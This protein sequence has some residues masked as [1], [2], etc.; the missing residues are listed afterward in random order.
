MCVNL[1]SC[2]GFV[3][4]VIISDNAKRSGRVR[5][6]KKG[7]FMTGQANLIAVMA[8]ILAGAL[9][10]VQAGQDNEDTAQG[11]DG[12]E[13]AAQTAPIDEE[14]EEDPVILGYLE[15]VQIGNLSLR[16]KGKL[17]T[18]ADTSSVHA[19]D[20]EVYK[21][22]KRDNWV[23]FRLVGKNGRAIRYDQNVIRFARIKRK[24]GGTIRRPVIRLPI[25]V[26]GVPGRAEVNLA[27]RAEF[28]YD[29]LIG[30]EFLADRII[31]D[32]GRTYTAD[33]SCDKDGSD[34]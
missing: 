26:G 14:N 1:L 10:P 17:D 2:H 30:R 8:F 3:Y 27:D 9:I 21:R 12:K 28:E 24:T 19:R 22:G 11:S 25:C 34:E 4:F 32:P 13:A 18:G 20:S 29:V 33:A 5:G 15:D 23:R 7:V 31:V 16:L 6:D